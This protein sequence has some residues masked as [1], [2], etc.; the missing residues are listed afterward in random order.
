[1]N[2]YLT[3][4]K[5]DGFFSL[6]IIKRNQVKAKRLLKISS[7]RVHVAYRSP[8]FPERAVTGHPQATSD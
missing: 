8:V 3:V 5:P 6:S 7:N 1:M 2:F 4:L